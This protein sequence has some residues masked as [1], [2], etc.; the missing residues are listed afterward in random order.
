MI[1][2]FDVV[3]HTVVV[4]GPFYPIG[5]VTIEI[6]VKQHIAQPKRHHRHT[7]VGDFNQHVEYNTYSH[8]EDGVDFVVEIVFYN[9]VRIDVTFESGFEGDDVSVDYAEYDVRAILEKGKT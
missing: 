4:L 5:S 6:A 1:P 3:R 8:L 2:D 9:A 7:D